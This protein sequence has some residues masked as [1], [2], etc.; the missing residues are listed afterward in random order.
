MMIS[1]VEGMQGPEQ[2]LVGESRSDE[3]TGHAEE[4]QPGERRVGKIVERSA[5]RA[6]VERK[7]SEARAEMLADDNNDLVVKD[8]FWMGYDAALAELIEELFDTGEK[9][10]G[11]FNVQ[12]VAPATLD[13]AS[14]DDVMAG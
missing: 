9:R 5:L 12:A 13:S 14:P 10:S 6:I 11:L 8:A 3:P 1:P 7:M 2:G 4:A